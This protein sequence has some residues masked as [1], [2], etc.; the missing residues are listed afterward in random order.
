MSLIVMGIPV[1]KR[2]LAIIQRQ[3]LHQGADRL[4][5]FSRLARYIKADCIILLIVYRQLHLSP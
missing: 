5:V 3:I 1:G 4:H 2:S